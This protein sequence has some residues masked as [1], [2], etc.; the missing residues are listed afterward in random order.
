[1]HL[2][3][4]FTSAPMLSCRPSPGAMYSGVPWR[5]PETWE[6]FRMFIDMPKSATYM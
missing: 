3:A 4:L 5:T 2:L 1:M 6:L